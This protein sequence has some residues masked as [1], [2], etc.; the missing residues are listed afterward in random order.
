MLTVRNLTVRGRIHQV[1]LTVLPTSPF[2][3]IGSNG[4]GKSTL[5]KSIA[6]LI[7]LDE[8][9]IEHNEVDLQQQS[10]FSLSRLVHLVAQ[11]PSIPFDYT[12][13]EIVAMGSYHGYSVEKALTA[14]GALHLGSEPITKLSVGERQRI[15]LARAIATECP[16]LLFD[17]PTANLDM[18]YRK[19][20]WMLLADLASKGRTV[21][22]ATHDLDAAGHYCPQSALLEENRCKAVGSTEQILAEISMKHQIGV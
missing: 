11:A 2:A 6:G 5:L 18:Y 17:E 1:T 7:P 19:E 8:G 21:I 15:Y 12:S 9:S 20:T 22:V 16:I 14:V 13:E 3:I 4:A 10:R